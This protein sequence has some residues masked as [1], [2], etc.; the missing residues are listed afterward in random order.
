MINYRV[1]TEDEAKALYYRY[2]RGMTYKE[3]REEMGLHFDMEAHR[4]VHY[5]LRKLRM[6]GK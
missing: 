3:V 5:A 2:Y 1:L 6:E 4:L